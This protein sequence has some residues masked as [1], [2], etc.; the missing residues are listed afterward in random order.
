MGGRV[1]YIGMEVDGHA[2][3]GGEYVQ[4]QNRK[5]LR[6][7]FGEISII[8][9]P[10]I[11]TLHHLKNLLLLKS[12][13]HTKG[14]AQRIEEESN[15]DYNFVFVEGSYYGRYVKFLRKRGQRIILFC[16]NVEY[17]FYKA[18]YASEKS[19]INLALAYY[20][21]YNESLSIKYASKIIALNKRDS[22][23]LLHYYRRS[24]DIILPPANPTIDKN[25]LTTEYHE[26]YLLFVG[27]NFY[28]NVDGIIWFIENVSPQINI[29]VYVAGGC[30]NSIN[31]KC[32][33]ANYPNVKLMGFVD[34]LDQLYKQSSENGF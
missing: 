27:A 17:D 28:A 9:V 10:K 34:N 4:L 23:G 3:T 26:K 24:S 32:Q 8:E 5:M 6:E 20:I 29:K 30:C 22:D 13:G 33:I 19:L 1:L 21:R 2:Q 14:L 7:L 12:Y 25:E 11:S 31:E 18:K 16:H 15:Y